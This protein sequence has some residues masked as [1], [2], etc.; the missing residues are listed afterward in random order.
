MGTPARMYGRSPS[1]V[2]C[3][4]RFARRQH[5]PVVER[6]PAAQRP[7]RDLHGVAR[8]A[9]ALRPRRAPAPVSRKLLNVSG[10]SSTRPRVPRSPPAACARTSA[11]TSATR[12]RGNRRRCDTP[13]SHFSSRRERRSVRAKKFATRANRDA[14]RAHQW[15]SPIAYAA[16]GRNRPCVVVREKL[17]LVRR[18]VDIDRA[19][20]ACTPCTPGT[21]PAP[22]ARAGRASRRRPRRCGSS[23]TASARARA[24][25]PPPRA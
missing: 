3:Q 10:Q 15:M 22:R 1:S 18:H 8:R 14:Q 21:D 13:A 16:R 4:T 24:W 19:V 12:T 7:R 6:A 23:R 5:A 2:R 25:S 17:R 20:A 11:G 9:R